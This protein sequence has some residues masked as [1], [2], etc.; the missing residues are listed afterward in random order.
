MNIGIVSDTHGNASRLAAAID[1][2]SAM[3]IGALVHC[4]DLCSHQCLDLL[5]GADAKA[6]L[7]AGN[8]DR[9]MGDLSTAA[10]RGRV[11]YAT[12]FVAV[13]LA[14]GKHLAATHGHLSGLLDEL[15]DG[16]QF[17]YVAHGHSHRRRDDRAGQVRVINPGALHHPR[18]GFE[19]S[20]AWLD[21][22]ADELRF[23]PIG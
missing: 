3:G 16:G 7:V 1:A 11:T 23:V 21:T 2:L 18:G 10:R 5:A 8:M 14:D 19:P 15:I 12:D 6:Y 9:A 22:R 20:C 17:P 4:G 13:P